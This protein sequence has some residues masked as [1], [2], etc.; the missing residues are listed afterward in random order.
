VVEDFF[1]KLTSRDDVAIV[2][3]NQ[4]VSISA[5]TTSPQS[6]LLYCCCAMHCADSL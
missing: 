6:M 2:L 5:Y 4:T 1:K 3:I